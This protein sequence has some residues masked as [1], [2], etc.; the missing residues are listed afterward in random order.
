MIRSAILDFEVITAA[1]VAFLVV[2]LLAAL[3]RKPVQ[4]RPSR[5]GYVGNR[6]GT[7]I[8]ALLVFG[9]YFGMHGLRARFVPPSPSLVLAGAIL[10]VAGIALA[11]WARYHLGQNWGAVPIIR[12]D[13]ELVRTG[14]YALMRHP[15]YVGVGVA[16]AGT[17][18]AKGE[19]GAL[20]GALIIILMFRIRARAESALL[21]RHFG[22]EA[23]RR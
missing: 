21:A 17:A 7:A 19:W 2:W 4:E 15:I 8:G 9:W 16:V 11:I 3:K 10:T 14:P 1:W 23:T 20:I 12:L 22:E 6:L 13:H 5:L 18:L